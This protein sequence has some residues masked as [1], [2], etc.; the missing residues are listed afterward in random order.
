MNDLLFAQIY[1]IVSGNSVRYLLI[2]CT[3]NPEN[4]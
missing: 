3:G 4:N 1:T 2:N